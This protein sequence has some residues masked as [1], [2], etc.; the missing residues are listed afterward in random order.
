MTVL[1]CSHESPVRLSRGDQPGRVEPTY[2][3]AHAAQ[4]S[5]RRWPLSLAGPLRDTRH[6]WQRGSALRAC[7]GVQADVH[8]QTCC[9]VAV[10]KQGGS[11]D[12]EGGVGAARGRQPPGRGARGAAVRPAGRQRALVGDL[13]A[14]QDALGVRAACVT[15]AR[16][17]TAPQRGQANV[18][19]PLR[20]SHLEVAVLVVRTDAN[21]TQEHRCTQRA[22]AEPLACHPLARYAPDSRPGGLRRP[23]LVE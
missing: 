23:H 20:L 1:S 2:L 10:R 19:P 11:P 18:G 8:M 7:R 22:C 6:A 12:A 4:H 16:T 21:N 13:A 9:V 17:W 5:T 3:R 15:H 14:V